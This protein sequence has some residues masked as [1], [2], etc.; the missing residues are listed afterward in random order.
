MN[1]NKDLK[2]VALILKYKNEIFNNIED[3]FRIL[4]KN[5]NS[6]INI[7]SEKKLIKVKSL[8][9]ILEQNSSNGNN[10]LEIIKIYTKLIKN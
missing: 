2:D 9:E 7:K 10:N 6:I 8:I 1:D 5:E 4:E 3:V